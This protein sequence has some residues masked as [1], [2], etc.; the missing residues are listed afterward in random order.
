MGGQAGGEWVHDFMAMSMDRWVVMCIDGW[1]AMCMDRWVG[2]RIGD[3]GWRME[4]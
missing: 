3:D 2:G 1:V 4:A